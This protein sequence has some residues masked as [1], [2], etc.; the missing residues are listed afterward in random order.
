MEILK[1]GQRSNWKVPLWEVI[2]TWRESS[3]VTLLTKISWMIWSMTPMTGLL[4]EKAT[5]DLSAIWYWVQL[6]RALFRSLHLPMSRLKPPKAISVDALHQ[7]IS[8][9]LT[10]WWALSSPWSLARQSIWWIRTGE[11]VRLP[12][13]TLRVFSVFCSA[14]KLKN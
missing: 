6:K 5:E 2:K 7:V 13:A 4:R 10:W 11:D 3:S 12:P 1:S 8:R 9:W 14:S